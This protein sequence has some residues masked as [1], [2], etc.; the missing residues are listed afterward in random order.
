MYMHNDTVDEPMQ[1]DAS[2]LTT[3]QSVVSVVTADATSHKDDDEIDSLT[4]LDP[5]GERIWSIVSALLKDKSEVTILDILDATDIKESPVRTRLSLLV[6]LNY[7]RSVNG[8]GRRPTYY[9]LPQAQNDPELASTECVIKTLE[10]SLASKEL[11]EKQLLAQLQIVSADKEAIQ[12]TIK[13][14]LSGG[15]S[16]V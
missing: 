2:A 13:V 11:E 1:S 9:F 16:N 15:T 10:K 7:L 3:L 12:R 8:T 5:L 14:L 6:K 4:S